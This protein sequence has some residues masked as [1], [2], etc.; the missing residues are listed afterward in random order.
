MTEKMIKINGKL[1][2]QKLEQYNISGNEVSAK[3]GQGKN[4]ISNA[5]IRNIISEKALALISQNYDIG[6]IDVILD[7]SN[8]KDEI[9]CTRNMLKID[10]KALRSEL[11]K[12][13]INQQKLSKEFG[14][15]KGYICTCIRQGKIR[16]LIFETIVQKYSINPDLILIREKFKTKNFYSIKLDIDENKKLRI[17]LMNE[18]KEMYHAN[19]KIQGEDDISLTKAINSATFMIYKLAEQ[20]QL[21][22]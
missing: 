15:G 22:L 4:Y 12:K 9:K 10:G 17:V 8:G 5:I 1:L 20:K 11:N 19:A 14:M 3:I 13:G 16:R 18:D 2:K 6:I 21:E 7:V